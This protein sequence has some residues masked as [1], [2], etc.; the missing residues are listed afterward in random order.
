MTIQLPALA[1][2]ASFIATV[3][4]LLVAMLLIAGRAD[5]AS[6]PVTPLL[7][8]GAGMGAKPSARVHE[9]QRALQRRG[10]DLG[11]PGV[12]GRFGPL[13]AAA[14]RRLQAARGLGVDGIVGPR[15]RAALGLRSRAAQRRSHAPSAPASSAP[16]STPSQPSATP[17]ETSP[18]TVT[19]VA[20]ATDRSS[21]VL[22]KV[23][24]SAL[25]GAMAAVAVAAFRRRMS[26]PQSPSGAVMETPPR[27]DVTPPA[28][29]NGLTDVTPPV[30]TNSAANGFAASRIAPR[31]PVI[32]YLTTSSDAWSDEHELSSAAIE[33]ACEASGLNLLEIVWDRYDGRTLDR[34]ALNHALERIARGEADG[35]VATDLQRL[36]RSP[37]DLG[38]LMAW[39]R[40][41]DAR[42]VALDLDLD[43][44]TPGGR[45]VARTL[46][47]LG[48]AEPEPGPQPVRNG[49]TEARVNGRPAVK[50]RPELLERI[51]AMRSANLSLQQI[52]DQLNA[53]N[54][55][56]LRGGT[57]WRPSSIQVALGYRRPSPR[58]RLP[59]LEDRGG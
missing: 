55:P 49:T 8:Q 38:A 21:G 31:E 30:S 22:I 48:A 46:I 59:P 40:D 4:A 39:L 36:S 14:V 58:D 56:T 32:G 20:P 18:R 42:L 25:I 52:A 29:T 27:A 19:V 54:V 13:T 15:T 34:P 47:A 57:Q 23:L 17:V 41:A 26:R 5:A 3:A 7:A 12:D 16:E 35:L 1:P 50:D 24:F 6:A 2:R 51:T 33:A 10:Y 28:S 9:M 44:A 11:A 37:Q 43:T 53:E 45:Q